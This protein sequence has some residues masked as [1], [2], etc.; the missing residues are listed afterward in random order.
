MKQRIFQILLKASMLII[1]WIIF[2]LDAF[3]SDRIFALWEDIEFSIGPFFSSISRSIESGVLPLRLDTILGGFPLYN[4]T[5]F[6]VFYPFYGF[7]IDIYNDGF[8]P[9]LKM[10]HNITLFHHLLMLFNM[11][12][13]LRI[14]KATTIAAIAGSIVF[15]FSADTHMWSMWVQI[16]APY[17]WLPLYTAA[18]INIIYN[19]N[20]LRNLFLILFSLCMI[21]TSSPSQPLIHTVLLTGFILIGY[22]INAISKKQTLVI[23]LPP[24]LRV[25]AIAIVCILICAPI[26]FPPLVDGGKL[27]RWIGDFPAIRV[28]DSVP[29]DAFV[30]YKL[31]L[32]DIWRL[33]FHYHGALTGGAYIGF[34]LIPLAAFSFLYRVSWLTI[35]LSLFGSYALLSSFGDDLGFAYLN[36]EI[37]LLN[38]IREPSRNLILF[39]FSLAILTS[40]GITNLSS[41]FANGHATISRYKYLLIL[42]FFIVLFAYLNGFF[43]FGEGAYI[44][45]VFGDFEYKLRVSDTIRFFICIALI[46]L[47]YI[48]FYFR[49]VFLAKSLVFIWSLVTIIGLYTAVPFWPPLKISSS[50]YVVNKMAMLEMAILDIRKRDPNSDY[51][52]LFDGEINKGSAAM[53]AAYHGVRTFSYYVNPAPVE[54]CVDFAWSGYSPYYAYQGA[55]YLI[56]KKCD[57]SQYPSF[58]FLDSIGDYHIYKDRSAY[59]NIYT[60]NIKGCF[61][62]KQ[63]FINKIKNET[64]DVSKKNA[65]INPY[66]NNVDLSICLSRKTELS[67]CKINRYIKNANRHELLVECDPG[68]AIIL[69]EYN[70]GNWISKINGELVPVYRMNGSQNGIIS[71]GGTQYV[72]FEYRPSV[73]YNSLILVILGILCFIIMIFVELKIA[74]KV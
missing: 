4:S 34:F 70:D 49:L 33:F 69:N 18:L 10:I 51:R 48:V 13:L 5:N 16:V 17:S 29:F 53:L 60:A 37:P 2:N 19:K 50:K 38:R 30:Y 12:Y 42:S 56:C 1:V 28:N 27:I 41:V 62:D 47:T 6:T 11:Y 36:H 74:T 31:P 40:I 39:H 44:K 64:I 55:A 43:T 72:T 3:N 68:V 71:T 7:F 54:Q 20:I 59:P 45:N 57:I 22:I 73:F 14:L 61:Y 52:V 15:T 32:K 63:D 26:L 58:T 24:L 66:I 35:T 25:F 67:S 46:I 23:I 21:I 9:T 65:Y 8:F